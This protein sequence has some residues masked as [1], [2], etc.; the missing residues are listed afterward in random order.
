MTDHAPSPTVVR[1]FSPD[2]LTELLTRAG[3]FAVERCRTEYCDPAPPASFCFVLRSQGSARLLSAA[4]VVRELLR[5]D[6]A[7]R[8]WI[9]LSPVGIAD[10]MTVLEVDY[11][12]RFTTCLIVGD[13][14]LPFEPIHVLGPALPADWDDTPMPK[15]SLPLFER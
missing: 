11:P 14:A 3:E 10:E 12:E 13:L 5:A 1:I 15:V 6:G 2:E 9:N 8:D 4:E 7:F